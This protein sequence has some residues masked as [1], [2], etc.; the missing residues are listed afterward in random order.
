M[1]KL[2]SILNFPLLFS[3]MLFILLA[4]V[5]SVYKLLT[6]LKDASKFHRIGLLFLNLVFFL[7]FMGLI[8]Q[9]HY[10]DS[11]NRISKLLIQD[12]LTVMKKLDK[13]EF[14]L[15]SSL[16][17][18]GQLSQ[19]YQLKFSSQ[20]LTEPE[21][22]QLKSPASEIELIGDGLSETQ[23]AAFDNMR[24]NFVS[25]EL[26][27][28][29]ISPEWLESIWLGNHFSVKATLQTS[30][31]GIFT[32]EL[33]DP[34]GQVVQQ[35][36]LRSNERFE[37]SSTPKTIGNHLYQIRIIDS[38]DKIV[39]NE[40]IPVSVQRS[41]PAKLLILQSSPSFEVKQLQNWSAENGASLFVRSRIS[42][43]KFVSRS[44]NLE[45]SIFESTKGTSLSSRSLSLY[46]LLIIDG[47]ELLS[48][49]DGQIKT[50]KDAIRD[51]LGLLVLVDS[52]LVDNKNESLADL[53]KDF[54]LSPLEQQTESS[55]VLVK[56]ETDLVNLSNITLPIATR[57]FDSTNSLPPSVIPLI[58]DLQGRV[59]VAS[60]Q[61]TLGKLGLSII[62]DTNRLVTSGRRQEFSLIWHHL[63]E[64]IGRKEQGSQLQARNPAKRFTI[65]QLAEICI[66]IPMKTPVKAKTE[67]ETFRVSHSFQQADES[68]HVLS[69]ERNPFL[70][71][72][73]C[74]DFWPKQSGWHQLL[75]NSLSQDNMIKE[76]LW[77]YVHDEDGWQA[78]NQLTTL[79][80]TKSR[81]KRN[82][83]SASRK[84]VSLPI[85]DWLFWSLM[86]ISSGLIW[87]ERKYWS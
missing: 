20:I 40:T 7:S 77:F 80:A 9:P 14:L 66:N 73:F 70:S 19:Q 36:S 47:R 35:L 46:D 54:P 81:I 56:S 15:V 85:S 78:D 6:R 48:I 21:Q 1:V 84:G 22:L 29:L 3:S 82:P 59:V 50:V 34:I 28:G 53:L 74:A 49:S 26:K 62:Q 76:N 65:N 55:I 23:L 71:G 4:L 64:Q 11:S 12:D 37:M 45:L 43:N 13:D 27:T 83:S 68:Q 41:T 30:S 72:E 33:V 31:N 63:I 25:A 51:G 79:L 16:S 39:S 61:L 10:N 42:Q 87:I 75:D 52:Y 69:F 60:S 18:L 8:I 17:Q 38:K 86:V 24:L 67:Q 2:E 58:T 5:L 57:P 44:T 32:V